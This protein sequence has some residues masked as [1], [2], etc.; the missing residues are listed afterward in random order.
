MVHPDGEIVLFNDA[1][2]G[3]ASKPKDILVYADQFGYCVDKAAPEGVKYFEDTG[4]VR[5][6]KGEAVAFLD[7]A[8][9]GPDY[10]PGHAHAD[11]LSFE[12]SLFGQ[13]TIVDSGVSCYGTSDVRL[14]QRGT[15]AHNTVMIDGE[16]SSE[17]WGGFRVARRAY[18]HDITIKELIG[19]SRV[20]GEHNGYCRLSGKPI[21]SREWVFKKNILQII[22]KIDGS[23]DEAI[24]RF[25]VHPDLK[26]E[27][28]EDVCEG[29]ILFS[30]DKK[31]SWKVT[32]GKCCIEETTW[33][34]EFGLSI[35]NTC[36]VIRFE[37][38]G[39]KI[40][41]TW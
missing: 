22:D 5:V 30:D 33:H 28:G 9:I 36:L 11:T 6:K 23:F 12:L 35:A 37:S 40:V 1:A 38:A 3:I 13:R 7:V 15:A 25:Y 24:G 17:V 2:F 39:C 14:H 20:F 31:V 41:F 10:L 4:Y 8:P 21:H 26:L 34:P 16:D 19:E 27:C 29:A 32:G 18:P